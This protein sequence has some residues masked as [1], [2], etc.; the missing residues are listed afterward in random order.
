MVSD[1]A[2]ER[3]AL[4]EREI[5][6]AAVSSKDAQ[7]TTAIDSTCERTEE[8]S[9]HDFYLANP[10]RMQELKQILHK[11]GGARVNGFHSAAEKAAWLGR[12]D[13]GLADYFNRSP[14]RASELVQVVLERLRVQVK[15]NVT[16]GKYEYRGSARESEDYIRGYYNDAH[17]ERYERLIYRVVKDE[18]LEELLADAIRDREMVEEEARVQAEF[19]EYRREEAERR[20]RFH[21]GHPRGR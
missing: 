7:A 17:R 5:D 6:E 10:H 21:R 3:G 15:K 19:K 12:F 18:V 16:R 8:Q 1:Q 14:A 13:R 4:E 11:A 2:R 20:A 9:V